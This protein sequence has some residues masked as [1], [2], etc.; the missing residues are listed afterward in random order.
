MRPAAA[1]PA[2][3]LLGLALLAAPAAAQRSRCGYGDGLA[4]L[5]EAA[6]TLDAA[7]ARV[8]SLAEGRAL[9]ADAAGR[10]RA[11]AAVLAG[12]GCTRAAAEAETAAAVAERGIS[13]AA[14]NAALDALRQAGFRLSLLR[15]RLGR[16]GCL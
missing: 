8:G 14:A 3:A 11:G 10:L 15:E 7:E 13:A 12:C 16:D 4:A 5:R 2:A 6:A 9:A 1:R